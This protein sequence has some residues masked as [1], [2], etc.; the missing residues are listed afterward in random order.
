MDQTFINDLLVRGVI[1]IDESERSLPQ[2]ILINLTL[3]ADTSAAGKSDRIEDCINYKTVAD[4]VT[5]FVE[6]SSC[7]TVE[8][9]AEDIAALCLQ[10]P[11]IAQ[12]KVRVEKLG[13]VRFAR[14]VG[15]EIV[16]KR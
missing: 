12:V 8:A 14:S 4:Q 6:S 10:D 1:G 13:V 15:V 2:N 11:R 3:F 5:A 9:L 7:C 16:R